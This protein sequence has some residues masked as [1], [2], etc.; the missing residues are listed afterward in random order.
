[1]HESNTFLQI[2][3]TYEH[4]RSTSFTR[5]EALTAR[6]ENAHHEL[7]GFIQGAREHKLEPIPLLATFAVPS[8]TIEEAAFE[9]I[10]S[11]LL[12]SIESQMPL[13]GLLIALH[14]ATVSARF[15]DA[16]GEILAR[17]RALVGP[18]LPIVNTLDLHANI[19]SSM[20]RLANAT[21]AYR[22]NPHLDQEERG[23]E[24]AT[25]LSR[26]LAG[27][28]NPRQALE[29][30]PL[31]IRISKQY[32]AEEPAAS[33]YR[34]VCEVRSWPHILSA[35]AALGFYYAD[36]KEMGASFLVVAE[37]D[38]NLARHAAQWLAQRVWQRREEFAGELPDASTAV[39]LAG[40]AEASP[41]ILMDIGDN[42]GAGSPGDST[43]LL[44]EILRQ[45][46]TNSLVILFDP[47][48][49]SECVGAGVGAVVRLTLGGKP[50]RQDSPPVNVSARVR[51]LS[52]GRFVETAVRHGG[53]TE[54]NQ[55]I[56]AVLE[57]DEQ[58]TI[59]LTSRR[60]APMSLEQVLSLGIRPERKRIIVVKGVVAPRA[61]YESIAAC[62]ILVD[63]PGLTSDNPKH[64]QYARR[65][66]PLYPLEE[67]AVYRPNV[68]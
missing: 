1:M 26:V 11:E 49:V 44:H 28:A 36:V 16:D 58:H 46:V 20:I 22:S 7:G 48:S 4:F 61:A 31:I 52:D 33:I 23:F 41:T 6:W 63:T 37:A 57:T 5:G 8:G 18:D 38:A 40:K 35:S 17:I 19:S 39:D 13:A 29:T 15:P 42:V 56:T 54:F 53:W 10:A 67:N 55:G 3:T 50:N 25:L 59:V 68:A 64:F 47:E 9:Q 51:T 2:P 32:T 14:G 65:R 43:I 30:P 60:M 12:E 24:A 21:I 45:K 62:I 66:V 27:E 34:D